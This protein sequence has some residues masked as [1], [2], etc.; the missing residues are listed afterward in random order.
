MSDTPP[1][2]SVSTDL[3]SWNGDDYLF[4]LL[5]VLYRQLL[6]FYWDCLTSQ[7]IQQNGCPSYQILACHGIPKTVKSDIGPQYST[8]EYKRFS[9]EWISDT[10]Q[11][12]RIT[13]KPMG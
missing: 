4:V 9:E 10:L 2:E 7:H 8:E 3:F 13:L 6:T 11:L 1:W 12:F 5:V